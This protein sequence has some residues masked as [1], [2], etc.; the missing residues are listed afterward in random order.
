MDMLEQLK[1]AVESYGEVMV[2]TD[3]GEERE[4]HKHNSDFHEDK[5]VIEVD[6]DDKI[7]WLVAEK[8]ERYYI[9]K[10]F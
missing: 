6:A 10:D 3:S 2:R 1:N 7:H 8:V 4:L 5:G 9:H